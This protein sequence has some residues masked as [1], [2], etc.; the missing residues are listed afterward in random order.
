MPASQQGRA[1]GISLDVDKRWAVA[2][3][4]WQSFQQ[5]LRRPETGKSV[6]RTASGCRAYIQA[7]TAHRRV[8]VFRWRSES[9]YQN[10]EMEPGR[11]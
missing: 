11:G 8:Y 4:H 1:E 10:D 2:C 5:E 6:T 9:L 7:A 3:K